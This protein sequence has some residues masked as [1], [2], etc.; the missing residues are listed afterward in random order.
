MIGGG[1]PAF[2]LYQ[3]Q[4]IASMHPVIDECRASQQNTSSYAMFTVDQHVLT[5]LHGFICP[6]CTLHHL[7]DGERPRISRRQM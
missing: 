4:G 3:F 6:F 2:P 7:F 1:L 5:M